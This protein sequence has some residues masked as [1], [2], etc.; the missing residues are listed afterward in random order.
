MLCKLAECTFHF[1][2]NLPLA[3]S[4]VY[5]CADCVSSL[6]STF[7]YLFWPAKRQVKGYMCVQKVDNPSRNY[8]II[9]FFV[10]NIFTKPIFCSKIP[11][12]GKSCSRLLEPQN[13]AP[14]AKSCSKVTE[15]ELLPINLTIWHHDDI[16]HH[17]T[18]TIKLY[19]DVGT[20]EHYVLCSF[21]GSITSSFKDI[22]RDL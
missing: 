10:L 11:Q 9:N 17:V 1:S 14:N 15:T 21:A 13:V 12:K 16:S 8:E 3:F 18:V 2:F 20:D 22:E 4:C 19:L 7:K 5:L 6:L